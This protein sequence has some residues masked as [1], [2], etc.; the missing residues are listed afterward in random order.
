MEPEPFDG[1]ITQ[2]GES[3]RPWNVGGEPTMGRDNGRISQ[4]WG[5]PLSFP[6]GQMLGNRWSPEPQQEFPAEGKEL[7]LKH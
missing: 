3:L 6:Q 7:K 4:K 5:H 1:H 2:Q